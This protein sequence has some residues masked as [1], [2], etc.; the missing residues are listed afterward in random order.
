MKQVLRNTKKS[1]F[2]DFWYFDIFDHFLT[3]KPKN[4]PKWPFLAQNWPKMDPKGHPKS[5][6]ISKNAPQDAS[7]EG[8]ETQS[9]KSRLPDP[10]RDPLMCWKHSPCHAF[11]TSQRVP[12]G[13]LS[14]PFWLHFG[15]LLGTFGAQKSPK[16]RKRGLPKKHQKK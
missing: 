14:A 13:S 3:Q 15:S 5:P 10:P 11:Y 6:K 8:L 16:R 7:K 4:W 12:P 2:A 9:G 1:T